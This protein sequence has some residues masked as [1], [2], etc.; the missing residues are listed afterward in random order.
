MHV[1]Q[2]MSC[3]ISIVGISDHELT[4][5]PIV[6]ASVFFRLVDVP[7]LAYEYGHLGQGS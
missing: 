5:L 1:L 2:E 3:K 6:T 7:L 4:G